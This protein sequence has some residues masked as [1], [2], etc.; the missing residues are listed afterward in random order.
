[1]ELDT[2]SYLMFHTYSGG[3][4]GKGSD[5]RTMVEALD[6]LMTRVM[7]HTCSNVLTPEQIEDIMRGIDVY[8][9]PGD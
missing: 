3:F 5:T 6:R 9:H 2:N 8:I 1:M 7:T 4:Q